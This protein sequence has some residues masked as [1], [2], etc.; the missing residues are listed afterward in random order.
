VLGLQALRVFRYLRSEPAFPF[1]SETGR[2]D[3]NFFPATFFFGKL[4]VEARFT[5]QF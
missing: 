3:K 5:H 4:W 1:W 2:K